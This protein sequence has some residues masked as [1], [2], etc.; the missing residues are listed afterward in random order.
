MIIIITNMKISETLVS[1][2]KVMRKTLDLFFGFIR[3]YRDLS[4]NLCFKLGGYIRGI[5]RK[6]LL[7]RFR[8]SLNIR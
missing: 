3:L 4:R 2:Q 6:T 5:R 1:K 8:K 7:N